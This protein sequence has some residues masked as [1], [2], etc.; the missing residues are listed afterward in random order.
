MYV[1][2]IRT[3]S[4]GVDVGSVEYWMMIKLPIGQ[5]ARLHQVLY[6]SSSYGG[7]ISGTCSVIHG[8]KFPRFWTHLL[9]I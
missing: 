1:V 9:K 6:C 3:G 8:M 7:G 5:S 2:N 4:G